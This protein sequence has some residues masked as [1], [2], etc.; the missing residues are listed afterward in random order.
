AVAPFA[1]DSSEAKATVRVNTESFVRERLDAAFKERN[2][3]FQEIDSVLSTSPDMLAEVPRRLDAVRSFT[4]LP[5]SAALAAANKRVGNILRKSAAG[6]SQRVD[7]KLL[8]E[9]AERDL[10]ESIGT[11]G[12]KADALFEAGDYQG[13]LRELAALKAPVD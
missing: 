13:S 9:K 4:A 6:D 1:W 2:Y 11:V 7:T 5:E 10:H 3:S 8:V 12:R